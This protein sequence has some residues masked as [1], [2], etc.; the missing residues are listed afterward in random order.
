MIYADIF[1][2]YSL[3]SRMVQ[4]TSILRRAK[5][6]EYWRRYLDRIMNAQSR[7]AR[8]VR[9]SFSDK[10]LKFWP[11]CQGYTFYFAIFALFNDAYRIKTLAC[12]CAVERKLEL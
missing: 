9:E 8:Y 4:L 10:W 5:T 6:P 11:T 12:F 1:A 2:G 7:P 3:K